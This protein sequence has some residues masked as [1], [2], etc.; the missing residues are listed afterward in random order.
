MGKLITIVGINGSGKTTLTA[1]LCQQT[2]LTPWLESHEDRPYQPLFSQDVRRYCLPNQMDYM[3]RR[4]EQEREVRS[5]EVTGVQDGGLDQ[6]YFLY[7]RLFHHK[8][9]LD[10]REFALCQRIYQALRAGLPAPDLIV[11]LR[12]P[13]DLLRERILARGREIDLEQIVTP[14]DLPLLDAYLEEW[15]G[16]IEPARL[17]VLD[18]GAQEDL[19][20]PL[21]AGLSERNL[22]AG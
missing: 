4:A 5:G 20:S 2:G 9:F 18:A 21:L 3:L 11:W 8:G 7:T 19:L 17:L 22:L 12:A 10:E 15:L 14:D 6:D 16:K 1:A 13:L